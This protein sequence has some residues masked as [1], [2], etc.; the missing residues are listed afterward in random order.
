M[1]TFSAVCLFCEDIRQ[2]MS[3]QDTI[4]G[5]L[6]DYLIIEGM[7]PTSPPKAMRTVTKLGFYIRINIDTNSENPKNVSAKVLSI[8]GDILAESE[9]DSDVIEK[10]FADAKTKQ[11]PLVGLIFKAVASPLPIAESGKIRAI[12]TVDGTDYLA[13]VLNVTVASALSPPTSQS[14]TAS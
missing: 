14:P 9:W 12:A 1:A 10:T 4:V 11:M 5:T 2:E 6:P 3:G 8:N 13:G 7:S